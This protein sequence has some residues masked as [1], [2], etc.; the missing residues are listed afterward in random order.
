MRVM[1]V[2]GSEVVEEVG[3]LSFRWIPGFVGVE[4]AEAG[5]VRKRVVNRDVEGS[6]DVRTRRSLSRFEDSYA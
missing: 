3:A 6:E 5:G 1:R 4:E 2:L